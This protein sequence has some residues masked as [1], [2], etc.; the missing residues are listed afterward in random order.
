MPKSTKYQGVPFKDTL[1]FLIELKIG[2]T[3]MGEN[4]KKRGVRMIGSNTDCWALLPEFPT[5]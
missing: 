1:E 4:E 5:L 3:Q 2:K